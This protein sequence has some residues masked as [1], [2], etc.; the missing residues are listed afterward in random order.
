MH[1]QIVQFDDNLC[2]GADAGCERCSPRARTG[3]RATGVDLLSLTGSASSS[4]ASTTSVRSLHAG[5]AARVP[6]RF[7]SVLLSFA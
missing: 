2:P 5:E 7:T 1:V 6:C 3:R 4:F